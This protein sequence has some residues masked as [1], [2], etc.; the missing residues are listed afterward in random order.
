[1]ESKKE[2]LG[3]RIYY[4]ESVPIYVEDKGPWGDGI[5]PLLDGHRTRTHTIA[6]CRDEPRKVLEALVGKYA[7]SK[8][9]GRSLPKDKVRR[10]HL[11]IERVKSLPAGMKV[12]ATIDD[13]LAQLEP[14]K[15][16]DEERKKLAE[17]HYFQKLHGYFFV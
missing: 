11:N 14:F 2:T 5:Y 17:K 12:I 15:L 3:T 1:M 10:K 16:K 7:I 13:V 9:L 6:Y 4:S 8:Y